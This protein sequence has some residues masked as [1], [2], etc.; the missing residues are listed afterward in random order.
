MK[1]RVEL[2]IVGTLETVPRCLAK[3]LEELEIRERIETIQI[4]AN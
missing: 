2:I 4:T 3:R 1:V